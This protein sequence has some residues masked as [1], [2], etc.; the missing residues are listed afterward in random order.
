MKAL[1]VDSGPLYALFDADDAFHAPVKNF[2]QGYSG[3]LMTTWAVITEV[4][5]LLDFSVNVQILFLRWVEQAVELVDI[6]KSFISELIRYTDKYRDRPMDLADASLMLLAIKTG[7]REILSVDADFDI[8]RL[9]DKTC[10]T[11]VLP[12]FKR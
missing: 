9:P 2:L 5:Y 12:R 6:E 1:L 11:N 7:I 4:M 8:Y 10:M 3:R